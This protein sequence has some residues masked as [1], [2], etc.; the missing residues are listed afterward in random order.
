MDTAFIVCYIS[1]FSFN[2]SMISAYHK[3]EKKFF[4]HKRPTWL[5]CMAISAL[6]FA[7]GILLIYKNGGNFETLLQ[8]W[9]EK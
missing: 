5:G 2:I 7:T 3:R 4:R 6:L 8:V 1:L 9:P